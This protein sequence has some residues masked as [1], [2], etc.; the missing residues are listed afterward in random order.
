MQNHTY[1][2]TRGSRVP[3]SRFPQTSSQTRPNPPGDAQTN[4]LT[5]PS[6]CR[7]RGLQPQSR[8]GSSRVS[9]VPFGAE[10]PPEHVVPRVG[11]SPSQ[12]PRIPAI[13]CDLLRSPAASLH[14]RVAYP[15]ARLPIPPSVGRGRLGRYEFRSVF[16]S[17]NNHFMPLFPMFLHF[18]HLH[19]GSYESLLRIN[20]SII[21]AAYIGV[22]TNY[23]FSQYP[24]RSCLGC[25][26]QGRPAPARVIPPFVGHSVLQHAHFTPANTAFL[27]QVHLLFALPSPLECPLP[28]LANSASL[29]PFWPFAFHLTPPLHF[30]TVSRSLRARSRGF[31]FYRGKSQP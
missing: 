1:C 14:N 18:S 24:W 9:R 31:T 15:V 13:S 29:H 7:F 6:C 2:I 22:V 11:K 21:S 8:P 17:G 3:V 27:P 4:H 23:R 26:F 28:S 12:N 25:G 10:A 19:F 20:K 5:R 30:P 16:A